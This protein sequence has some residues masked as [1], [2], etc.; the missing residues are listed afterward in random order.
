SLAQSWLTECV[1]SHPLCKTVHEEHTLPTRIID[2]GSDNENIERRPVI[3]NGITGKYITLSHCWGNFV[4][5]TTEISTMQKRISG[6][7][8]S[9]LPK[10]FQ[11]AVTIARL[12]QIKYLWINSLCIV[13]D[14]PQDWE[15]E[16]SK[17]AGVYSGALLTIIAADTRDARD[18]F[19]GPRD[20][21]AEIP[22]RITTDAP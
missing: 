15:L 9:T 3:S 2:V 12:L 6:I 10:T 11:D 20:D 16:A 4:P 21:R 18:G 7:S 1:E 17:M 19:L 5:L 14:D 13:Q 22:I 8:Y